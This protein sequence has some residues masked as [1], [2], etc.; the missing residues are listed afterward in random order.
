MSTATDTQGRDWSAMSRADFD[1]GAPLALVDA[2]TVTC[3]VEAIPDA[4]GT[5]ALF[6]EAPTPRRAPGPRR[7]AAGPAAQ[8]D[9]LF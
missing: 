5:E 6:G 1:E 9:A 3:R 8:G 4:C 7:P 2:D